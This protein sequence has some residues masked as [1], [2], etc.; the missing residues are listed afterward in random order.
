MLETLLIFASLG[1]VLSG[2][3]LVLATSSFI[4]GLQLI[5]IR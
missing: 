2:L 3:G 4:G 1:V 5:K